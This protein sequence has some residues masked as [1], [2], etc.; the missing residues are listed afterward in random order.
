MRKR[1]IGR[2]LLTAAA[3]GGAFAVRAAGPTDNLRADYRNAVHGAPWTN[4]AEQVAVQ[5]G[6]GSGYHFTTNRTIRYLRF[7]QYNQTT[8]PTLETLQ[9]GLQNVFPTP[10]LRSTLGQ[11]IA[12]ASAN[13][14][15][16]EAL[17]PPA[18]WDGTE[19][20][21]EEGTGGNAVWIDF[22]KEVIAC[23]AGPV[24]ITWPLTGGGTKLET[25]VVA[26]SP[27][28]RPVRLYWT[29]ER[30]A[31][32]GD[33][34]YTAL[35]NAGPTVTFGQ[36]Y[37]VH[38]YPTS[39]IGVYDPKAGKDSGYTA[40]D[41]RGYV[42]L[43]GN[44]LQA[45][46]GSYGTFL[47]VYSRLDEALNER[48]MLAYE[49]VE[50]LEPKQTQ[51]D[52]KIGDQLKP[53]TRDFSTNELFPRV[54]RGLTD[55]SENG[56][57]YVYQHGTGAQ[58]NYLWA[59][60]DS[61]ANPWKIEVFWRAKEELDVV[62][63]FEVDIYGASWD[64]AG[65]QPYVRDTEKAEGGPAKA[66]PVVYYPSGLTVEAMDYQVVA[67]GSGMKEQKHLHVS[68]GLFYSD[69]AD[70]ATY[71]LLK[72]TSGDAVWFQTVRSLPAKASA[73][74]AE[75]ALDYAGACTNVA[76]RTGAATN[77]VGALDVATNVALAAEIRAPFAGAD[78]FFYPGW[79]RRDH[80]PSARAYPVRNPY[81]AS[82]Y[83]YP[84]GYRPPDELFSPIYPVNLGELEVWWSL[85]S[86]LMGAARPN[87]GNAEPLASP[88]YFP[89]I[90]L[91]YTVHTPE[92]IAVLAGDYAAKPQIVIASGLGS[93]GFALNDHLTGHAQETAPA[94][95]WNP[96]D[97]YPDLFAASVSLGGLDNPAGVTSNFTFEAR[98]VCDTGAD[99]GEKYM[100]FE[101][102]LISFYASSGDGEASAQAPYLRLGVS[103]DGRV[104]V[105][106]EEAV[107][108]MHQ[109][110]HQG[111][112]TA[113]WG[114]PYRFAEF[115]A[116]MGKSGEARGPQGAHV[117]FR[118]EGT[119][120]T[121]YLNGHCLGTCEGEAAVDVARDTARVF[122][123]NRGPGVC[124]RGPVH[125]LRLWSEARTAKQLD[126]NRYAACPA[127]ADLVFQ[128]D[129]P[130][131]TF[132]TYG[133]ESA[134]AGP[135]KDG[136]L[137]DSSGHGA[138]AYLGY[139]AETNGTD[140]TM[141][142][143]AGTMTGV[144]LR[145]PQ[146]GR[147]FPADAT[148][149]RQPDPGLDGYNP[150][151]EHALLV[152]GVA[153]ALRCDLNRTE[154]DG[155]GEEAFT[156]LPYALVQ[157]V[158]ADTRR[159]T[160]C[161]L[162]VVPEND[163]YRFRRY[164]TAGSMV[165]SPDPLARLQ[166]ANLQ[167]FVSGPTYGAEETCFRD[168]KG[169]F[170]AHQA[171]DDGGPT[172]YV[173]EI[174]YPS[175]AA[176]DYP[177]GSAPEAGAHV[178]WMANYAQRDDGYVWTL[179]GSDGPSPF[180]ER[181]AS[182]PVGTAI[183]YTYV[184][185][186]PESV[187]G[188]YVNDT[189]HGAKDG[190]PAVRGQ[191]SAKILY[192]QSAATGG[193]ASVRLI[194][195][196][197]RQGGKL[198]AIPDD[199][200]TYRDPKTSKRRFTDLPPMLR[201][202]FQWN[203]TAFHDMTHND[204]RELELTGQFIDEGAYQFALLN[205][206]D[207]RSKAVML[208]PDLLPGADAAAWV[209]GV[210]SVSSEPIVLADD[211]TPFTAMA[212]ATTGKG[213]GYV[214]LVFNDSTNLS[215]VAKSDVV[216]MSVIKVVPEL[217][218]G[219]LHVFQSENPLDRQVNVKYASD[220]GA[221]P[222]LW[223]FEWQYCEPQGGAAAPAGDAGA[224]LSLAGSCGKPGVPMLDW[225][226]VGDAGVF[227]LSDH[228]VRCR[229]RAL[230]PAVQALVGTGWSGWSPPKLAEGWVKRVLKAINP[231]D[232]KIRDFLNSKVDT[233][234]SMVQQ[235][236][237][238]YQGD[239]PLN[240]EALGEN[241]LIAIYET[242]LNQAKKLSVDADYLATESLAL[243]LQMAAG[244]IAELYAVLGNEAY[245]DAL[246]PTVDL[247][248][249]ALVDDT[250]E[251]SV[252]P[253]MNQCE[254]LLDEELCLLRGR[255]LS[256]R[257]ADSW[258]AN[259]EPWEYPHYNRLAWNFTA[260][261]MG[262][263][264]AYVENYG[265]RDVC[266]ASDASD[267]TAKDGVID[268]YDAKALYPQGHGD[269]WGH[270]LS[271]E[272]GYYALLRHPNFG[273]KPQIEG[274]LAG[275]TEITIGYLHEKR[276]A[277]VAE[278]K[279]KT[280]ERV[281][282]A[283]QR[284]NYV[285]GASDTW[286]SAEDDDGTRAWG[287][288]EWAT[289]AHLG[290]YY[291]W[292]T[293]N[294]LLPARSAEEG[295]VRML[296]REST[297]ELGAIAA[298]ARRIQSSADAADA[299]LNPLG[300]SDRAIPF[301]ISPTEID[302]GK[303]HFEQVLDRAKRA[304]KVAREVFL[305]A[306]AAANALR[307]QNASADY[308]RLVSDEEAA[309]ERRLIEI[310]GYPYDDDIG[311]GK[312]YPQGYAGPDIYHYE[313]VETYDL[314]GSG[315]V[316]G[317]YRGV[318]AGDGSY[319]RYIDVTVDDYRL[320]TTNVTGTFQAEI[321]T[322]LA[323]NGFF[324]NIIVGAV[325][326]YQDKLAAASGYIDPWSKYTGLASADFQLPVAVVDTAGDALDGKVDYTFAVAAWSNAPWVASYYVGENGFTP[327]P[328]EF[329]G[330]R[331]AEGETQLALNGYAKLLAEIDVKANALFAANA[332]LQGLIDELTT[333]DYTTQMGYVT[334]AAQKEVENYTAACKKNAETVERTLTALKELK[335]TLTESGV[336]AFP[337]LTGLSFDL[338][339]AGRA[340]LLA[341][342]SGVNDLLNGQINAQ[343][344]KVQKCEEAI[345]EL[346]DT[347][348]KQFSAWMSNADRQKKI[349]AIKE[350]TAKVKGALAE[351]EIAFTDA[352][353]RRMNFAKVVA[354]GDALQAERERLRIQW[355]A[356]LSQSRYRNMTYQ[357]F[358][359]DALQRYHEAFELAAKYAFLAAKAYDYETGLLQSD[360][361]N[362]A[363]SAFMTSIVK[364]RALGRFTGDGEPLVGGDAGDPGLADILARMEQNWSV[365]RTRLGFNNA[366]GDLDSFSL[367]ADLFGKARDAAGDAAWKDALAACWIDDL[368][369]HPAFA[370]LCQPFD[371]MKAREPG[372]A[373]PFRTV[374]A[375]RK[376]LFGNDLMGG[377]TAYSSTYF[378]TKLRAVGVWIEGAGASAALPKRPEVYLVPAGLDF[379][380]VP[381]K[382]SGNAAAV[383]TWQVVD[384]VLP[385]PYSL[386]ESDW[387]S[388]DWSMLKDVFGNEMALE[389]R[390]PA[391]RA[392]VGAT[393]DEAATM[394]YNARLVGRSVWNDQWYVFIP[395]ASL[396][397]DDAKAKKAFLD[398]VR[399]I[400]LNLKTYSFSG[401]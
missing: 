3:L 342:K 148:I 109:E 20:E 50:V 14:F 247:G 262:G 338:T 93:A 227:G 295:L 94:L 232:Q 223:E 78:G 241:G 243:S 114:F 245:A 77:A 280:G 278:M 362:T 279:A 317:A 59:I 127:S 132:E 322:S 53:Q 100:A 32:A 189:L 211:V 275:Q 192:Q 253:F 391:I 65:A 135:V 99:G 312:T 310:Y 126:R 222:E 244:R 8:Y 396:N 214:T 34:A 163:M 337:K 47:I 340:A 119:T 182:D 159:P 234:L 212:L 67:A 217:Y 209:A 221:K 258:T 6:A 41:G 188:L 190:L 274:I 267:P 389:R 393:F 250:A 218:N 96:T 333:L 257:Y 70:A 71:A 231:F 335:D 80:E 117:V 5:L 287:T 226:T 112:V 56:E 183:D 12:G 45:F 37:K 397:A 89:S 238:P 307:D 259:V 330:Q 90:P 143:S 205:A 311:P 302:A 169:W 225:I 206:M 388:G 86:K 288:D 380:R 19:P 328:R 229:Y 18:D 76:Y 242:L 97:P 181:D 73:R 122:E 368:R 387:E 44:E 60:R 167:A 196:E 356:D 154:R 201:D 270:Y 298:S 321:D 150:N 266:G 147:T 9:I 68:D 10:V 281:V 273:W 202:R 360:R 213:A 15:L 194:D 363:G 186:W 137:S 379:M 246:N 255:D 373:I 326:W 265:I 162:R 133:D 264:V 256:R 339:S 332:K 359:N 27:N 158:D 301:D 24:R 106:G 352:N 346:E 155:A 145:Q 343:S 296:D 55:E 168:R 292:A 269:A 139:P 199:I 49:L 261:V 64:T 385:V 198:L 22:A 98:I 237:A 46:A 349:A 69:W 13:R 40:D 347:L 130:S 207:A 115:G 129:G 57:V 30:P 178:P 120:W 354:E 29:H 128:Y 268:V 392:N 1:T 370:R 173:F 160:M 208:D 313:Y 66:E 191:L 303:T 235:A 52:V 341:V 224:W 105:N 299:G 390:H 284:A 314:D 111:S 325:S 331:K 351:L 164:L 95:V 83:A 74:L 375:A 286:L 263:Q 348:S 401:N 233:S 146:P 103:A 294:A 180:P 318:A 239:I 345:E 283:T 157:Y 171:G 336:E 42:C 358:R 367:R 315:G 272:K 140:T 324:G 203:P 240:L 381:V 277:Q 357:I 316:N 382:A 193:V 361:A 251:G 271:A 107:P 116:Q 377:S 85:P 62:W 156:S 293:V 384:Q 136:F 121:F 399:D 142:L 82:L 101:R 149:Y 118:H 161:A 39:R 215:M 378:A 204:S 123:C 308:E 376:D 366:Q 141:W 319:G 38:L 297:K 353:E 228:Y 252:F 210:E 177:D 219:R 285:A 282:A 152:G 276:F 305:R 72:Y 350:Q 386:A 334:D 290:A 2:L 113:I 153:H 84:T 369:T 309:I 51:I 374:I 398:A 7:G 79:I 220:F 4:G 184:V 176:F 131:Q 16:G 306:K 92:Q 248:A 236:G 364:A 17:T 260:D 54:T 108:G 371:P 33:S 125:Y 289:R 329:H 230:D 104:F 91:V 216:T 21:I 87:G 165:Q 249:D 28:K 43:N 174:S 61:S 35:Q 170:W 195:P 400:H 58:K 102:P 88:V 138:H 26:A 320:V 365:L 166:P 36:N 124:Y 179:W 254:S 383:R 291:D 197:T 300:L 172:N 185:D 25:A 187:P 175:Q 323:D 31:Y 144:A 23:E 11:P 394:T 372:F 395:A 151:E 81:N 355:A 75:L 327:K 200:R 110:T 63:P 48:R 134:V 304:T 344:F